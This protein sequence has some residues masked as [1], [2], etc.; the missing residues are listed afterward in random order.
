[1]GDG[2]GDEF[3]DNELHEFDDIHEVEAMSTRIRC[4]DDDNGEADDDNDETTIAMTVATMTTTTTG[5]KWTTTT[6][7][8]LS[9]ISMDLALH[10]WMQGTGRGRGFSV[11]S[12]VA[13]MQ[14]TS[15]GTQ[16]TTRYM[17]DIKGRRPGCAFRDWH[18]HCTVICCSVLTCCRRRNFSFIS[19]VYRYATLRVLTNVKSTCG[20]RG[21]FLSV[22]KSL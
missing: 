17:R 6:R 21:C 18:S 20:L 10:G 1:M 11:V 7:P 15:R 9:R 12:N 13:L 19:V 3:D 2:G 16:W 4:G 14:V 22:S 5:S 8:E